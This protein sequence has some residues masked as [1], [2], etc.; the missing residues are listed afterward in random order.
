MNKNIKNVVVHNTGD[1]NKPI[2]QII[3]IN[4]GEDYME[5]K[6]MSPYEYFKSVKEKVNQI[7]N[8]DI[9]KLYTISTELLEKYKKTGQIKSAKK[10][11]FHIKSLLKE[12]E[13]IDLGIT[14]FIYKEDI[15]N[16]I[17]NVA[18]DVVKII[19]LKNYPREIPD[20]LVET[21]E[22]TKNIFDEMYVLFT[23]YTKELVEEVNKERD[24]ILFG[25]F[26]D[27]KNDAMCQRLYYLGDWIDEYCDLTLD[28]LV[29][30]TNKEIVKE[31]SIPD[32]KDEL[33]DQLNKLQESDKNGNIYL[34]SKELE[35]KHKSKI[36]NLVV[37]FIK[38][39]K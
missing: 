36:V 27:R 32:N 34:V 14:K 5:E 12:K 28:K 35:K 15:E 25:A 18:K 31:I 2:V 9:T 4:K 7:N 11:A 13:I 19:E 3:P 22:K 29:S 8:D 17:D 37:K 1:L 6:E 39:N 33:I 38:G 10:L 23:D 26:I 20:E 16:Y 30:Q 24:P 21:I